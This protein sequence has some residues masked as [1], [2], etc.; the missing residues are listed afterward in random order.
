MAELKTKENDADVF[1][2]IESYANTDQK[3]KDSIEL[4]KIMQ[5]FTGYPPKMWG[6]SIIGFGKY[7]YQSER[8]KQ[9]G[10]WPL[11]GFSPRKTALTLYVNAGC[12]EQDNM[13]ENLGK[14][15]M[16][17]SCIYVK[18]LSDINIDVLKEIMQSTIDFL[19][20]KYGKIGE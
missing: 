9:K 20:V 8:S 13:L 5:E 7:F 3:K 14:Y 18:K 6:S 4:I 16:G 17:K 19:E 11:L 15:K 2:F 10:H 12:E 1:E